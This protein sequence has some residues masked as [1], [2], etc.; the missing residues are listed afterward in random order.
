MASLCRI[1]LYLTRPAWQAGFHALP[2]R[3]AV[4]WILACAL[5]VINPAQAG[6]PKYAGMV[7]N[8]VNGEVLYAENADQ[9]R[10]P[11]S[12]TKMMTLYMMFE[13]VEHG[14]LRLDQALPVSAKAAAAPA[15]KLWL[16]K[17][18]SIRV[19]AAIQ[20][21]AVRSANDVAVVVAEALAGSEAAFARQMTSRAQGLGMTATTFRNASGLPHPE[22][23]TT[24]RDMLTLAVRLKQDFPHF[25]PV[26]S[27]QAFQFRGKTYQSHNRLLTGYPGVDGLKTGYIRASGF[28]LA[29]TVEQGTKR[30]V[31]IVMG[32]FTSRSRD[33]HMHDLLNRGF[34]RAA[35]IER[36]SWLAD[37]QLS[38]EYMQFKDAERS[39][40]IN[41]RAA[42]CQG[43]PERQC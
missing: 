40:V 28:N 31:G 13:A 9:P 2:Q 10:Y 6:N 11:A 39:L 14:R 3:P 36:D 32:G 33:A 38:R 30:L 21:L 27:L 43:A 29:T 34:R 18:S 12:L 7:V 19:E 15:I 8:P 26:F 42:L 23:V 37:T 17:G 5:V 16:P 35:L 41:E 22:Q 25:Y 1:L 20:A 24:A 4:V